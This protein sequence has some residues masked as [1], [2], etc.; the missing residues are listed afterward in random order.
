MF[1]PREGSLRAEFARSLEVVLKYGERLLEVGG[2]LRSP[3]CRTLMLIKLDRFLVEFD[4][5]VDI[6]LIKLFSVQLLESLFKLFF[7]V[8]DILG[9]I[10]LQSGAEGPQPLGRFVVVLFDGVG[11]G[12]HILVS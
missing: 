5:R 6:L 7:I 4:L 11:Q 1:R 3:I 10:N 2:Q 12:S 8:R 9:Q